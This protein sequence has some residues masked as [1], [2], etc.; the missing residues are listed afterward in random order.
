VKY[1]KKSYLAN[2]SAKTNVGRRISK[3]EKQVG[4]SR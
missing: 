2:A 4:T 1:F 3:L